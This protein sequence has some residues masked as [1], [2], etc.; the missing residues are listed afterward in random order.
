MLPIQRGNLAECIRAIVKAPAIFQ[1]HSSISLIDQTEASMEHCF[2]I[3]RIGHTYT[4]L[5]KSPGRIEQGA[6]RIFRA[7]DQ[8]LPSVYAPR[9]PGGLRNI[10]HLRNSG[11]Y[12]VPAPTR[13]RSQNVLGVH[14]KNRSITIP[15]AARVVVVITQA[16]LHSQLGVDLPVVH[17]KSGLALV[18]R[19]DQE[20]PPLIEAGRAKHDF[21]QR[22]ARQ[23]VVIVPKLVG[24]S[25][26]YSATAPLRSPPFSIESE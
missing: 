22:M 10:T 4:R 12:L 14:I 5:Q 26:V 2:V 24:S 19:G 11:G 15:M 20:V 18:V 8:S 13:I 17:Q 25:P 1:L 3:Q 21:G 23:A 7:V 16:E 6:A 9:H